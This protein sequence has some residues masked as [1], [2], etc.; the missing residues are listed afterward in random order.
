MI[1]KTVIMASPIVVALYRSIR[2]GTLK[3]GMAEAR[4]ETNPYGFIIMIAV[5]AVA[6]LML[7]ALVLKIAIHVFPD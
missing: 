3:L 4:W 1:C 5:F 6:L 7:G 2:S